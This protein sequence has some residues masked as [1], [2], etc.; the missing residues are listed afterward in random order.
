MCDKAN[1]AAF[2][3]LHAT[4]F[5]ALGSDCRVVRPYRID[6]EGTAPQSR[7]WKRKLRVNSNSCLAKINISDQNTLSIAELRTR[8]SGRG[9]GR[10][11][12]EK[13]DLTRIF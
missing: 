2:P 3:L 11:F 7:T 8:V 4:L 12:R 5:W 9:D 1:D 13:K 10:L 6:R